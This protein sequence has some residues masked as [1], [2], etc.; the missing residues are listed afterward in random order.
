MGKIT[1]FMEYRRSE[2]SKQPVEERIK[3][4]KEFEKTFDENTARIQG[5]RCMDCGIPFCHGDTGCPV[6]NLIPE[7][8]DLVYRGLWKEALQNLHSTN[9]FPEFTGMLCPAPCESACVL[10]LTDPPVAI[11][12]IERF[13]IDRGF[14]EGWVEPHPPKA[15]SNR[16]VAIIGSGPA[17]L[18]A[19]QQLRRAGHDVTV[20]ERE[21]RIGGLIRYGIPDFKFEK[22][23]IDRRLDQMKKEGVQFR[24]GINVGVDI[25]LD[26]LR[27]QFDAVILAMGAEEPRRIPIPGADLK[28]VHFAMD[29]LTQAN[30]FVAGE[31]IPDQITARDKHVIVI[32]GGDTGSDCIGTA[33]RQGAKSVTQLDYNPEPPKERTDDDPWPLYP[34]ILRTS[35]SHEEGVER[36]WSLHTKSFRGESGHVVAVTG[37]QVIKK[38]RTEIIDIPGTEFEIPADLVLIAIGFTGPKASPLIDQLKQAG[39]AFDSNQNVK[40]SFGVGGNH[41]ATTVPGIFA[42]GDVRRGQSIIVWAISEGRKCAQVVD[43]YL[44]ALKKTD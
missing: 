16:S 28:G 19:A 41:F 17:G 31:E 3:H 23:R 7:W 36:K 27:A 30:R 20:F 2:I 11:K 32:G 29:Y 22:W 13:I 42:A 8:N 37:N 14:E 15:L 34:R 18:A 40:A 26:E 33:N 25:T 44:T 4:F 5:A 6:D 9:N 12:A 10:G 24:T 21:D 39:V 35:T 38:S 1:G 43:R